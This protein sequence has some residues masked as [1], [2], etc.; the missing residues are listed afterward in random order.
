MLRPPQPAVYLFVL[1]V[2][3]LA[4]ESGYLSI[5]CNVI[6][7]ELSRLPGDSRTQ[8]GFL[9]VDS[10]IHFFCIPDNVSQPQ[11]MIM[12]DIDDVFLPCPENLIVNLKEREELVRDLLAQLPTKFQGTHDTNSA[13]GA[14]LQAAYK[15]ML[16]TGGRVTVFQTCLP[17]MGPGLLQARE[18]PNTRRAKT[19]HT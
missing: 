7:E 10:A 8:I 4:V 14:A 2:S 16:P 19:C 1:D 13:L 11:E 5:V 9:A 6:S 18:D 15:L 12:L 17:N 3:R